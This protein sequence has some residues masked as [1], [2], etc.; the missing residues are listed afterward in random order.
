[1][2]PEA[3]LIVTL[4]SALLTKVRE[5]ASPVAPAFYM[6]FLSVVLSKVL[7]WVLNYDT[8]LTVFSFHDILETLFW[9][10]LCCLG[11]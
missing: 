7:T 2:P 10:G 8:S 1:M 4:L 5:L 11:S 9:L 3:G 6:T